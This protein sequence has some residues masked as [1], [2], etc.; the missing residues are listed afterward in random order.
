MAGP[1]PYFC[2]VCHGY[3]F[4]GHKCKPP[5]FNPPAAINKAYLCLECGVP[6]QRYSSNPE[7]TMLYCWE[8][9]KHTIMLRIN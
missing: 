9:K 5:E 7:R 6:T 1:Q 8:C 4:P 3:R 2:N